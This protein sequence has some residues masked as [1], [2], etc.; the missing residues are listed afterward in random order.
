MDC[1]KTVFGIAGAT[2]LIMML[3]VMGAILAPFAVIYLMI[4]EWRD[5]EEDNDD[6]M[7]NAR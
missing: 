4:T 5:V 7:Y 1:L 2:V 6:E 3:L